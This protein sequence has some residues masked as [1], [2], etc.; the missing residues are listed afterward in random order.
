MNRQKLADK[1]DADAEQAIARG[2]VA[3]SAT[4]GRYRKLVFRAW[5]SEQRAP[6]LGEINQVIGGLRQPLQKAN[7]LSYMRGTEMALELVKGH[8][9]PGALSLNWFNNQIRLMS[10]RLNYDTEPVETYFETQAAEIVADV[11]T[12]EHALL[13]EGVNTIVAEGAH[14]KEGVTRL[15][16]LLDARGLG[17]LQTHQLEAIMRTQ[18]R[19]SYAAG[20]WDV[21]QN[22]YVDEII[23]GYEYLTVGDDRV[24]LSHQAMEGMKLPKEDSRWSSYW[25][26]NGWNCRCQVVPVFVDDDDQEV[27]QPKEG[28]EPDDQFDFNPGQVIPRPRNQNQLVKPPLPPLTAQ[29]VKKINIDAAVPYL[30]ERGYS[31]VEVMPYNLK[32]KKAQYKVK[33]PDG[34]TV[35]IDS[36]Q[37]K[38][39]IREKP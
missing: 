8:H 12:R 5:R 4:L 32:T 10:K 28:G 24:R 38:S 3:S 34:R 18:T 29:Q 13:Q 11:S 31:F 6:T 7:T 37:L 39:I 27:K 25:P 33:R 22:P 2:L 16:E 35:V 19:M 1:M 26:P 14:T 20:Q 17:P 23:W 9:A 15:G 36:D 30:E 21:Y